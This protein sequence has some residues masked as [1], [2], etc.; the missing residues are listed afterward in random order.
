M[1]ERQ[2]KGVVIFLH[3]DRYDRRY[4]AASIALTASS[5]GEPVTLCLFF[6]ALASFAEGRWSEVDVAPEGATGPLAQLQR[7]FELA[8][9][10]TLEE[11]LERAR[12]EK[13]GLTVIA[14]ST[15]MKLLD[16]EPKELTRRGV[17]QVAGLPTMLELAFRSGR[18]IAL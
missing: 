18:W 11:M 3:S 10:P 9:V 8:N 14:C 12:A 13:G 16:L 5:M 15:S 2:A 4:Q 7:G 6:E 1:A 17:D